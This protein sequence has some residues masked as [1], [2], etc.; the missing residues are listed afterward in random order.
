MGA[1]FL[2][3]REIPDVVRAYEL[4][5]S[6]YPDAPANVNVLVVN[7]NDKMM[8]DVENSNDVEIENVVV[9]RYHHDREN[10]NSLRSV[11]RHGQANESPPYT[12]QPTETG[13]VAERYDVY[14]T[15]TLR[16]FRFRLYIPIHTC[17]RSLS[18]HSVFDVANGYE[19]DAASGR[20][21]DFL[22]R[23]GRSRVGTSFKRF[24]IS[25]RVTIR[26]NDRREGVFEWRATVEN[27]PILEHSVLTPD[28]R[29]LITL[30]GNRCKSPKTLFA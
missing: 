26:L 1:A 29:T 12:E 4:M 25:S 24:R 2:A 15:A 9:T 8:H 18:G 11:R 10:D 22:R 21:S 20:M 30:Q 16:S 19:M 3:S 27:S 23:R 14:A 6:S 17:S 5:E 7:E 28:E 13:S